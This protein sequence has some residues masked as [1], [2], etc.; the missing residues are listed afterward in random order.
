MIRFVFVGIVNA[1]I[2]ISCCLIGL[3]DIPLFRK[4]KFTDK[5]G[6][7]WAYLILKVSSVR[8][9]ID[10]KNNIDKNKPYIFVANHMSMF[11]IPAT[12]TAIPNELKMLAKKELYKIPLF[13]WVLHAGRHVKIDRQ[14]R[15]KAVH[16]LDKAIERV[17]K[18]DI[19]IMV[20]PEGTRST[21]GKIKNFKKGAFVL[22]IKSGIP[23]VPVTIAGSREIVPKK[24][25]RIN[26]GTIKI[27]IDKPIETKGLS[28][29][30]KNE[31]LKNVQE[32]I[33]M[34]YK[35]LNN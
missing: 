7:T 21:D 24:S 29:D 17:K 23:I 2:T 28:L 35:S 34:Q 33:K 22:A 6:K 15:E 32:K 18:G 27:V 11:D 16:H 3:L 31:L 12:I 10:G 20:Y 25:L 8:I 30:D 9:E 26:E 1:L 14:N 5:V 4:G 19:S 13:G